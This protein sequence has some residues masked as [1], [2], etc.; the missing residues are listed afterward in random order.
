MNSTTR[1]TR[2]TSEN[3]QIP[4]ARLKLLMAQARGFLLSFQLSLPCERA[5]LETNKTLR[6]TNSDAQDV[7]VSEHSARLS[8]VATLASD[9]RPFPNA[10]RHAERSKRIENEY[11]F[12]RIR[13]CF[14]P[15]KRLTTE[16]SE[17]L[18][19]FQMY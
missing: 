4:S 6:P 15:S 10:A 11:A 19:G 18:F 8:I 7:Y 12:E 14:Y 1:A 5:S 3:A 2:R 16:P 13:Y 9:L 17:T